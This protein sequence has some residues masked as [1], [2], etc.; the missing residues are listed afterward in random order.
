MTPTEFAT[1][2]RRLELSHSGLAEALG[3]HITTI[4]RYER[5]VRR[6]PEPT[7]KYLRTLSKGAPG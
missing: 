6:I 7:A 4:S 2:R 5:G 3:V 1:I